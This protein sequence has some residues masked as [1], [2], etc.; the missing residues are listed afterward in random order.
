MMKSFLVAMRSRN[1]RLGAFRSHWGGVPAE[2]FMPVS[3]MP[4]LLCDCPVA[5]SI[6]VFAPAYRRQTYHYDAIRIVKGPLKAA[7]AETRLA[8]AALCRTIRIPRWKSTTASI[9]SGDF[10]QDNGMIGN[11]VT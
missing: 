11:G 1:W 3:L 2:G 4:G 5:F 10:G 8:L 6:M 7:A 9:G